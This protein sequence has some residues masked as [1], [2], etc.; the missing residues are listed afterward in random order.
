[1]FEIVPAILAKTGDELITKLNLI[2]DYVA[3]AQIDVMDNNFVSNLTIGIDDINALSVKDYPSLMLELHLMVSDIKHYIE[4]LSNSM[5]KLITFH[6]ETCAN[7]LEIEGLINL[8][9]TKNYLAGM[10]INPETSIEKITKFIPLLDL[11]LVMTVHPGKSGQMFLQDNLNKVKSLALL[12]QK[13][14]HD[15]I[16]EVD[17]GVNLST[18]KQC[19]QA[20]ATRFVIG[21]GIYSANNIEQR[22]NEFKHILKS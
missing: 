10:A 8:I 22:I 15:F 6:Y 14:K 5:V 11:V 1:M 17:G 3:L 2:K 19:R 21:S 20:G 12:K 7:D 13:L 16:I 9:K 4:N 18:I